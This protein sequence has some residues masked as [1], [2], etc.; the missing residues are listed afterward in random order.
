MNVIQILAQIF[1]KK[2]YPIKFTTS[3]SL[4]AWNLYLDPVQKAKFQY[5]W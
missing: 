1:T 4:D 2:S 5:I 3:D